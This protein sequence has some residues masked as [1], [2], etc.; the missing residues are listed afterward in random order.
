VAYILKKEILMFVLIV[1]AIVVFVGY[2]IM[3]GGTTDVSGA[4][5]SPSCH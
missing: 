1:L 5:F 3:F 4:G 2:I